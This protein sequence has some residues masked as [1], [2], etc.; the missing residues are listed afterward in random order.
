MM[1]L[2]ILQIIL[3]SIELSIKLF[4][5]M[6]PA[7]REGFAERHEKRMDRWEKLF[8]RFDKDEKDPKLNPTP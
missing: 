3:R 8:D 7:Q 1:T 5:S 6:T 4:D 2:T